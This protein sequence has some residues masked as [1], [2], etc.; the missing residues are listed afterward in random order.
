[1]NRLDRLIEA[2]RALV[3]RSRYADK[4][5]SLFMHF[6]NLFV[7]WFNKKF[8]TDFITTVGAKSFFPPALLDPRVVDDQAMMVECHEFV[9]K[10]DFWKNEFTFGIKYL[11]SKACRRDAE[12]RGYTMTM[13]TYWLRFKT[14]APAAQYVK[15]FTGPD[16]LYMERDGDLVRNKLQAAQN[17]FVKSEDLFLIPEDAAPYRLVR[18][19]FKKEGLLHA[20]L[21]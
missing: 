6:L 1:M 4:S 15:Y 12:L 5:K 9:H 2:E 14:A 16:Y 10:W 13:Y 3:P 20:S 21:S 18:E 11:L 8:M 19:F 17:L 7:W